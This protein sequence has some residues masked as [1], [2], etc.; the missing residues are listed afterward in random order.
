MNDKHIAGLDCNAP[1]EEMIRHVLQ[2]QVAAMCALRQK[3]LDWSDPE[4]VHHMRVRSRRLRSAI[5]D[6]EPYLPKTRLPLANLRAIARALGDVRDEDVALAA[7]ERLKT[8]VQGVVAQGLESLIAEQQMRR[9]KARIDLQKA[10][11][12]SAVT[13]LK[14]QFDSL[15]TH[16]AESAATPAVVPAGPTFRSIGVRVINARLTELRAAS[17]HIFFPGDNS[18]LHDLRIL[19][20]GLRYAVELFAA[21]W[22]E[23]MRAIAREISLLQTSLGELHDCDVWIAEL[24]RRLKRTAR[25]GLADPE[26]S[27]VNAACTWLLKHFVKVRTEHYGD[28]LGRWQQWQADGF[29]NNLRSLT[30]SG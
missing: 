6:F 5:A 24:G 2:A 11:R 12:R 1:A 8:E 15:L 20:K 7:M 25:S 26:T 14:K 9:D 23:N 3:A 4:G 10:I 27:R 21:C 16:P 13:E 22:G 30:G 19:A 18:D 17:P 28:A 29:L